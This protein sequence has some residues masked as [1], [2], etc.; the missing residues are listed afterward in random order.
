LES[1]L[2]SYDAGLEDLAKGRSGR[3]IWLAHGIVVEKEYRYLRISKKSDRMF[4]TVPVEVPINGSIRVPEFR[5][6]VRTHLAREVDPRLV[7]DNDTVQFDLDRL[8]LPLILRTRLRGDTIVPKG[9]EGHRKR[10]SDFMVDMKIPRSRRDAIPFLVSPDGVVWI[11]GHR[12]DG[13][14]LADAASRRIL[15]VNFRGEDR[16]A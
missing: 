1:G 3:K 2:S 13:R 12:V 16:N 6:E 14:Y 11:I 5:G 4:Q 9:M 8:P 15:V 10:V 7:G